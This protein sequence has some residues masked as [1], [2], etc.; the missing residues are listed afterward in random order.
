MMSS[1]SKPAAHRAQRPQRAL[2]AAR[3]PSKASVR[4]AV[5]V[6]HL[7]PPSGDGGPLGKII[8]AASAEDALQAAINAGI[9]TRSGKLSARFR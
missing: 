4:T 2:A 5:Q 9:I 1:S 8:T 7:S 6:V 3:S